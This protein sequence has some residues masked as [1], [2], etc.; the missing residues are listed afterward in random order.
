MISFVAWGGVGKST[1]VNKWR[2]RLAADNYRGAKRV[3]A[4]SFYSQGTGERVTSAD[5]FIA[6]A[7][8]WFGDPEMAE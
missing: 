8:K 2:E 5:I 1:L 7:L 3:F 4:W 6:E